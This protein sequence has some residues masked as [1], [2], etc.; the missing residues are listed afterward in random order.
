M[1]VLIS[2]WRES[3]ASE[4]AVFEAISG[5]FRTVFESTSRD[6]SIET[7]VSMATFATLSCCTFDQLP[8]KDLSKV[9]SYLAQS[10]QMIISHF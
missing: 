9:R 10:A 3:G 1:D 6:N 2:E 7:F 8:Q 5:R 4:R